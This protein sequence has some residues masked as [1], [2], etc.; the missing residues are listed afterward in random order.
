M[1]TAEKPRRSAICSAVR[2]SRVS[3]ATVK[4]RRRSCW[5]RTLSL[6]WEAKE[7]G[8]WFFRSRNLARYAEQHCAQ[9]RREPPRVNEQQPASWTRR[10]LPVA[11]HCLDVQKG[12]LDGLQLTQ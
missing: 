5:W 12:R 2:P 9:W 3:L 8:V 6:A 7:A 10:L 4:R 11:R 1:V